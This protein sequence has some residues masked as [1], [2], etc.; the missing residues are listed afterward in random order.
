MAVFKINKTKDYTVM[1]NTH[2]R[3]KKMSLKA[4]GLLSIMLSLPEDWDYSI[5]GLIT[6]SKDGKDSISNTLI[7]LEKFGYL[8]R[9]QEKDENGKFIGYRY[10]IYE[11]P[12]ADLPYAEKPIT[13]EPIAE[14]QAQIS[15][16]KQI[17]KKT[18][19]YKQTDLLIYDEVLE[20]A[21]ENCPVICDRH[22]YKVEVLGRLACREEVE[23]LLDELTRLYTYE[24][25][26]VLFKKAGSMYCSKP[27]YANCDLAWLL[28][29]LK[30]IDEAVVEEYPKSNDLSACN[31]REIEGI[32]KI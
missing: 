14:N 13:A 20:L 27:K 17:T 31:V 9:T 4:K 16:D 21:K 25:L 24:Q 29:N 30:A 8:I 23:R 22:T 3:E 12:T 6:L 19:T 11:V 5:S 10:D 2:L 7:E 15:T 1:S 26:K 28:N 18:S 32:Y